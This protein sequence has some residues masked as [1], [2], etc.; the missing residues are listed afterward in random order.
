MKSINNI[1][2]INKKLLISIFTVLSLIKFTYLVYSTDLAS[3][4][5]VISSLQSNSIVQS[6]ISSSINGY[7]AAAQYLTNFLSI[8]RVSSNIWTLI[9]FLIVILFFIAIYS[10]LFEVFMQR[11]GISES[12]TI[13]KSKILLIF[14]LSIFS[15]IAIGYAIPFLLNLYGFILLIFSLVALFFLGRATISYGKS[16]YHSAKTFAANVQKD[17]LTIEKELKKAENEFSKE[18]REHLMKEIDKVHGE[19]MNVRNA[20]NTAEAHFQTTL[21]NLI[22]TYKSFIN[23]LINEYRNY[24]NR[25]RRSLNQNQK[26]ELNSLIKNLES[27]RDNLHPDNIPTPK[28]LHD[29]I[30]KK[31]N[32][33]NN[34]NDNQKHKLINIL[35]TTYNKIITNIH[36]EI[37]KAINEYQT[38]KTLLNKFYLYGEI[39]RNDINVRL[40]HLLHIPGHKKYEVAM[41]SALNKLKND[42]KNIEISIDNKITFLKKFLN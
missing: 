37:Q 36:N 39:F 22:G 23:D 33:L 26:N 35:N 14:T 34:F 32:N 17:L 20:L 1:D 29:D 9:I 24:L 42:I 16:F 21:S 38:A 3:Q 28:E 25:H 18:E 4:N 2:N 19:F 41:L 27:K 31:I 6:I 7:S 15:A 5:N 40:R 8:G 12:S 13:R 30:L 10:F 11:A